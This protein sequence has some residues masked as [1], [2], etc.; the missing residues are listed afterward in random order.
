M[1]TSQIP[2]IQDTATQL[3]VG[4]AWTDNSPKEKGGQIW[5]LRERDADWPPADA[6]AE[7]LEL[8]LAGLTMKCSEVAVQKNVW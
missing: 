8:K 3:G 6:N 4:R 2:S 5:M 1:K 7:K